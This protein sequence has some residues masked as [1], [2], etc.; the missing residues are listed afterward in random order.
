V[1]GGGQADEEEKRKEIFF[2]EVLAEDEINRLLDPKVLSNFTRYTAK[3]KQPV[4]EFKRDENGV[5]RENLL[6]KGTNL[7]ALHTLKTQFRG[8]VKLIYIDPPYN[9]GNDSFG[10]NDSFN[11]STWLTFM[12]NR[13][14]VARSLLRDDGIMFCSINHIELGYALVLFDEIFGRTNRLPI[15][16]LKAGT[17]ASYRSINDCPVNVTEYVIA[18]SKNPNFKPNPVYRAS[19][20]SEDYSHCIMNIKDKPAKWALEKITDIIHQMQ[21]CDDWKDFRKKFGADWKQQRFRKMEEFAVKNKNRVV[22]LNTLQKPSQK[23]QD[24][25]N[26]S[27]KN[28]GKVYVCER[29]DAEPIFC[30]SGRTLAF[31]SSKFREIDGDL[32][33]S[34]Y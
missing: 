4:K 15:I 31:F 32:I 29:E 2:N 14:E 9:T 19:S 6:L 8:Q 24:T 5:I 20:Y 18:Y 7:L 22:S 27:Y 10:Y 34:K 11:H 28:R 25:I 30:Y 16:T 26:L 33:P 3:G 17:T 21:G 12:K 23:I 13:L 1:L